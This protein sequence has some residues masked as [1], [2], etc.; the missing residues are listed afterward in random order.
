MTAT[1]AFIALGL[2]LGFAAGLVHFAT[3]RRVT[4]LYLTGGS[5]TRALVL[6]LVRLAGLAAILVL[7]AGLGA[8]PLLAAALGVFLARGAVLRRLRKEA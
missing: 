7:F 8:A 4:D 3:L 1:L 2:A 6:Q 5:P